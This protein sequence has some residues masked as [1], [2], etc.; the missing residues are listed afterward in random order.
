[1]TKPSLRAF[2]LFVAG[3]FVVWTLRATVFYTFD[4]QLASPQWKYLYS[5]AMK[6]LLWVAPS[7]AF[8]YLRKQPKPFHFLGLLGKIS[9][10]NVLKAMGWIALFFGM[11]IAIE[12]FVQGR[13]LYKLFEADGQ[14]WYGVILFVAFSPLFEEILFRGLILN[15]LREATSFWKANLITSVL[16]VLIH[17]PYWIW[18]NGFST[19]TAVTSAS[20]FIVSL[21]FGYLVKVTNSIWPS[22]IAH[23]INNVLASFFSR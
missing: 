23:I 13:S 21:F 2:W 1:M 8:L 19:S 3:F 20:L 16:F 9:R 6:F 15:Q 4:K 10:E 7:I 18:H 14:K 12:Y 11:M 5:N 22:T 17:W